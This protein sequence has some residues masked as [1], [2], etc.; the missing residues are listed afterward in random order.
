MEI[1]KL[2]DFIKNMPE[3]I[4]GIVQKAR[5]LYLELG[6]RSFYDPE[7]KYFM[8]GEENYNHIHVNKPYSNPNIIMCTTLAKQYLRLLQMAGINSSIEI[9]D[10]GE[11]WLNTF[12]DEHFKNH[13]VDITQDLKNIQFGCSTNYF[14]TETISPEQLRAIDI[15]LGYISERKGYS[16][17]YWYIVKDAITDERLTDKQ[18]LELIFAN[19]DK[20]GDPKKPG[21]VEAFS[22]YQKFIRYAMPNSDSISIYSMKNSPYE[23]E[24][25]VVELIQAT[26]NIKYILN[27][28][29]RKFETSKSNNKT[30]K[31]D[32]SSELN[33]R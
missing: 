16:D 17:E 14:A 10:G 21:I 9:E 7:Y 19:L 20:L 11:H 22:I 31:T 28:K 5:Y 2:E 26:G 12:T 6:K 27:P 13:T 4:T 15:G 25:C 33:E 24:K 1:R 29:S 18:R 23:Q 8:F 32:F 30:L 3:N